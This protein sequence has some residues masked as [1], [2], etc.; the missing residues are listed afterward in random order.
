MPAILPFGRGQAGGEGAGVVARRRGHDQNLAGPD[1]EQD[2]G[3]AALLGAFLHREVLQRGV[4]AEHNLLPRHALL[5]RQLAH[6]LAIGVDLDL[7][8]AGGAAQLDVEGLLDA[9]LADAEVGQLQQRIVAV[10]LLL[11]H[12]GDIAHDMR[13]LVAEGIVADA[14]LLDRDAG[15]FEGVDLDARHLVPAHVLLDHHRDEAVLDADLAHDAAPVGIAERHEAID[16]VE[17]RLDVARLVGHQLGA[18]GRAVR[19]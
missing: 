19:G 14:A 2:A 5:A 16:R 13:Q 7:A 18:I 10:Q 11:R 4:E 6:H 15:Q 8:G 3:R 17:R 9:V 1:V 12:G